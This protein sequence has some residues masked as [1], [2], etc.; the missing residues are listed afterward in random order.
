M[1]RGLVGNR[2][3]DRQ[4]FA[5]QKRRFMSSVLGVSVGAGA[6]RMARPVSD[7]SVGTGRYDGF[8]MQ[9]VDVGRLRAEE[10]TAESIGVALES[11]GPI[12]ATGIAYR[13][14]QQAK[15]LRAAMARQRLGNYQLVPEIAASLEFL[16]ST[17]D[18]QG[19]S[20]VAVY[21]LG[22]SGLS[23]TIVDTDRADVRYAERTSEISGD[24]FDSLIR[25]QQIASGRTDAPQSPV[26]FA[27]L[28][29]LCR[30]AKEQLSESTAVAIPSNGG[31][32][33]LTRDNF[34]ALVTLAVESS[35]RMTRDVIM[36]SD[37]HVQAIIVIGGG[38]R[39]PLVREVLHRWLH[40]PVIVPESPES[41]SARGAALLARPVADR[42]DDLPTA[43]VWLTAPAKPGRKR[44]I[45]GAG[46]AA[47]SLA[48]IAAIGLALGYGSQMLEPG[49]NDGG[50]TTTLPTTPPRTTTLE[51][52]NAVAP[53]ATTLPP[54]TTTTVEAPPVF[55]QEEGPPPPPPPPPPPSIEIPG[56]PPI[57]IPTLPPP[58]PFQ[59]PQ[60]PPLPFPIP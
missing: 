11:G 31:L 6:I 58:P 54:T 19:F 56:L 59:M 15:G 42:R 12:D 50:P 1:I 52:S 33:L 18:I 20:T 53:I 27:A 28:D 40:V 49:S 17:G 13:S 45:S 57:L 7:P 30:D 37:R 46:L 26:E 32:V 29:V 8:A 24:Y 3:L 38:A 14:E 36:R 4:A 43:P 22:S 41:V 47:S 35:A 5:D 16:R 10:L 2:G 23:I 39:I 34:E 44:E 48:V 51:P 21:D 25:E 60:I 55:Q 9:A